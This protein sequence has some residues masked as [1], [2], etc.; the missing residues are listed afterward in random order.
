MEKDFPNWK[1]KSGL[2]FKYLSMAK[3]CLYIFIRLMLWNGE[4]SYGKQWSCNNY[5]SDSMGNES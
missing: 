2:M 5:H 4:S 3:S 1:I